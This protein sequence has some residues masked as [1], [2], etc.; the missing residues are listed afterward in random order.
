MTDPSQPQTEPGNLRFLRI[1]VTTLMAVMIGGLVI[2]IVLFVTR[3]PDPRPTLPD[4]IT[5]PAGVA[6]QAV[7]FG[8]GWFAVVTDDNRILIFDQSSGALRQEVEIRSE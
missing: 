6:A 4:T 1:L 2:L 5:L 7:T 8:P 3:F